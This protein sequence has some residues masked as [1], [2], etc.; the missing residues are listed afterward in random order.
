MN[1]YLPMA[2]FCQ[3]CFVVVINHDSVKRRVKILCVNDLNINKTTTDRNW[4]R[5]VKTVTP[6]LVSQMSKFGIV[7]E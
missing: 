2:R 1:Y 4:L 3:I 7:T 5:N 6:T